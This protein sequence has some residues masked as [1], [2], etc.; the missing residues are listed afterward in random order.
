MG[1]SFGFLHT[2]SGGFGFTVVNACKAEGIDLNKTCSLTFDPAGQLVAMGNVTRGMM[3]LMP[4]IAGVGIWFAMMVFLGIIVVALMFVVLEIMA[5]AKTYVHHPAGSSATSPN[6]LRPSDSTAFAFFKDTTS[7]A[8]SRRRKRNIFRA[9]GRTFVLSAADTQTI[10]VGAFLLGFAGQSKCKLTSYHFTVAVNQMMI[11][12]SSITFSVALVRTYWRNPLAAGFRLLL[13]MGAFIGVGLT[14]FRKAN[15]A[16]DWPPPRNRKESVMLMPV[17]CLLEP[18]IR[19]AVVKQAQAHHADIGFDKAST[20]P[21]E[22]YFFIALI[23]AFIISHLSIPLRFAESRNYAPAKWTKFRGPLTIVYWASMLVPPTFVSV[24]CWT[25]VYNAREWVRDSG[26]ME[27]P[28]T[29]FLIWD[30]G[31]L[32][33]IGVLITVVNNMLTEAWK[34]ESKPKEGTFQKIPD[35]GWEERRVREGEYPMVPMAKGRTSYQGSSSY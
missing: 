28:N 34:R 19:D 24:W 4:G 7:A 2:T 25:K 9:A 10:F 8:D 22:R 21:V 26:W 14:I 35:E 18:G 32:I 30:S 13:S 27:T 15:Y 31:Q 3:E 17:A 29:E 23:V 5:R 20:W 11:A 33:A 6:M 1:N 16:P 12:L